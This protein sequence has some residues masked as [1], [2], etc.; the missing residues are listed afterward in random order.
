MAG[1]AGSDCSCG[2]C[3]ERGTGTCPGIMAE[4]FPFRMSWNCTTAKIAPTIT[5]IPQAL[6]R[7]NFHP[8]WLKRNLCPMPQRMMEQSKIFQLEKLLSYC[9]QLDFLKIRYDQKNRYFTAIAWCPDRV[10]PPRKKQRQQSK[11]RYKW[12][13]LISPDWCATA[14]TLSAHWSMRYE[15]KQRN[16]RVALGPPHIPFVFSKN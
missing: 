5:A 3:G 16:V 15:Q 2:H 13:P 12:N 10:F 14:S 8:C 7:S 6:P 1:K 11:S 9:R 4:V